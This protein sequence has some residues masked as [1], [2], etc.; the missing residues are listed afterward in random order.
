MKKAILNGTIFALIAGF[1][2][3]LYTSD[4]AAKPGPLSSAHEFIADCETCHI[5]WQGVTDEMCLQCHYFDNVAVFK[6]Q[7]RFHEA[8]K[9]CLGCHIEHRGY[10]ADI[11]KVDH[12]L[13]HPE[14]SC[15]QCH[16]DAHDSKFGDDCRA[17][18]GI[19]TWKIEGFRH[20]PRDRRNCH[21]C[22]EAPASHYEPVFW[23][24][25]LKKHQ[26]V[27]DRAEDVPVEECWSCHTTYKWGHMMMEHDL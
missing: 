18:H 11:A 14:L 2:M 22:H 3:W 13:F 15:T 19:S 8:E 26:I 20:P 5:P 6:P 10:A 17:C 23:E 1:S 25:I 7:L 16:F 12:T 4:N 24:Q 27:L 21:R 9:H